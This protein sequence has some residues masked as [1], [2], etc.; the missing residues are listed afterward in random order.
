MPGLLR[1]IL[2][3]IR[4]NF[5]NRMALI[6]GYLFPA[7]FLFAFHTLYRQERV[8]LALHA[9]ELLTVTIL[10]GACF[11]LPTGIVSD[12]ERGVWR[13]YKLLP[14]SSL[15]VLG[16]TLV[17]RYLLLLTAGLL[18]LA[19]AMAIGMPAPRHPFALW[20]TY[21][22]AAIAFMGI[23][24]DIAMLAPNVPAVQ[25]LGQCIFLPMLI[26]GGVAVPLSN[27]PVWAQHLSA[28]L[29]G[30]Y[31]VEAIQACVSGAGTMRFHVVALLAIGAAGVVAG[32]LAFRWDTR[33]RTSAWVAVA[34]FGWLIAGIAAE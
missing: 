26:V 6:Y 14:V 28:F 23:G 32:V 20:A 16:G 15:S 17:T 31:S 13:R 1:Q 27:L 18:Q 4:L 10:G 25:A 22:V 5:R 24:L 34:V 8:P 3:S 21:S 9:G 29:P 11:G 12:R 33:Q 2:L 30:R 7:I 19:L